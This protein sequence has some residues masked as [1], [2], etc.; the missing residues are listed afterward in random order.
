MKHTPFVRR[1]SRRLAAG[2]FAILILGPGV[3]RAAEC[4]ASSPEDPLE[5][6]KLAKE[7]FSIADTAENNGDAAEATRAYACSYKMVA[8]ANTAINLG[9]VAERSG[10][11][12]LALKMFKAYLTLKPDAQDK[13]VVTAKIKSLEEKMAADKVGD[14]TEPAASTEDENPAEPAQEEIAPPPEP[15]PARVVQARKPAAPKPEEESPSH[16][17][18]WIV[19]GASAAALVTGIVLNVAARSKMNACNDDATKGNYATA[20]R[21]CNS[22]SPLANT[23]YVMFGLAA[24]GAAAEAYL[25]FI[26]NGGVFSRDDSSSSSSVGLLLLPSGGGLSAQGRF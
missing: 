14:T 26:H 1:I 10:N 13:E 17:A 2:C 3:T 6:R 25:L 15:K 4:P 18:E 5:R 22:A 9:R 21:E 20:N 23:S 12:E 24:A 19:G 11:N 8:H 7:W 16:L